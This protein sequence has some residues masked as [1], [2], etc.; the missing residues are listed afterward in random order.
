MRSVLA[1][2]SFVA[3]LLTAQVAHAQTVGAASLTLSATS[4]TYGNTV[5]VAGVAAGAAP[6]EQVVLE[7][8]DGEV[9]VEEARGVTDEAGAFAIELTATTA[10][11]FR[12]RTE[13]SGLVSEPVLLEV[14]P[15]VRVKLARGRAFVGARLTARVRPSSYRGT[16]SIAVTN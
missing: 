6:G 10:G 16:A 11:L 5:H 14:V 3:V 9:W 1:V 15:K 7:R 12:A 2:A 4:V 8:A 13:Q